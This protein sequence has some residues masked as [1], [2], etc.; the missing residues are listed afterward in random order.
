MISN[1]ASLSAFVLILVV[2]QVLFKK[3]GLAVRG[4]PP[5]DALIVVAYDPVL[6]VALALYGFATLLW[7]WILS[8]V[9]LS[10]AYPCVAFGTAIVPLLGW[11]LFGERI[12]PVFWLGVAFIM[13]GILLVHCGSPD[14]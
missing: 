4:L 3:V 7:I 11:Y 12:A 2:G 10:Q 9:P 6:Y 8:R 1:I 14:V 5:V 13:V